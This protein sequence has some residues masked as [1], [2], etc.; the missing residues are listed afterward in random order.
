MIQRPA[1]MT[2]TENMTESASPPTDA[3]RPSSAG[4]RQRSLP[5]RLVLPFMLDYLVY[6]AALNLVAFSTF[7]PMF[8]RTLTPSNIMISL[9]P[10]IQVLGATLPTAILSPTL[11]RRSCLKP[12]MLTMVAAERAP[13]LLL[14][15]L[16]PRHRSPYTKSVV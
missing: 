8:L 11:E 16:E 12:F 9:L 13:L 7:L 14:F 3:H 4:V 1:S 5:L 6:D 2:R 15:A 10:A